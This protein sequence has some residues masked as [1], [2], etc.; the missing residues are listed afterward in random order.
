[1][2]RRKLSFRNTPLITP[3]AIGAG[4][5]PA[6]RPTRS[7]VPR[8]VRRWWHIGSPAKEGL[9]VGVRLQTSGNL[10]ATDGS[11]TPAQFAVLC[12]ACRCGLLVRAWEETINHRGAPSRRYRW[13]IRP[14]SPTDRIYVSDVRRLWRDTEGTGP[15]ANLM[16][17]AERFA[18]RA[19]QRGG[20][21]PTF[22]IPDYLLNLTQLLELVDQEGDHTN[23]AH[24]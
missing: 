22:S 11:L 15:R 7:V 23:A 12:E 18:K 8:F 3:S 6:L 19:I 4:E 20:L 24:S 21:P 10:K 14:P 17:W 1:M 13:F 2:D 9:R 5:W 16:M